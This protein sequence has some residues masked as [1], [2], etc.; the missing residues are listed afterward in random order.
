[1]S[2][3]GVVELAFTAH[4]LLDAVLEDAT[5]HRCRPI[6]RV[7]ALTVGCPSLTLVDESDIDQFV[8]MVVETVGFDGI[9]LWR[10]WS[11]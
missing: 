4:E 11:G 5:P 2:G 3:I 10:T 9:Y 6:V 8:E 7:E 1:M